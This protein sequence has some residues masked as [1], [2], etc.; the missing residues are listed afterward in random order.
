MKKCFKLFAAFLCLTLVLTTCGSCMEIKKMQDI[1]VETNVPP[2]IVFLGDSIASGCGLEGYSDDDLYNCR[3]Y[4]NILKERY[5]GE[6][7]EKCRQ[8]TINDAVTGDKS[9]DMLKK[10]KNG[11]LD[12][13][14]ADSDAVVVSIGG[15][16]LLGL[17]FEVLTKLGYDPDSD[18]IEL[19]DAN[20]M[21]AVLALLTLD[22]DADAALDGFEANLKEIITAI[23]DKTAGTIIVQT[24]YDPFE[25]FDSIKVLT[26]FTGEK[27]ERLNNIVLKNAMDGDTR[28][29]YVVDVAGDFK[30]KCKDLTNIASFDIHP[31]AKG[32]EEIAEVVD[33]EIRAHV[34]TYPDRIEVVDQE[35]TNLLLII[36]IASC[37]VLVTGIILIVVIVVRK[38]KK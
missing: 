11:E 3:S 33:K 1:T 9:E 17:V 6:L 19:D 15:N 8:I 24:L 20:I 12:E 27:I 14:L 13:A 36:V 29:Y 18:K 28:L 5:S 34:Y 31:N 38:K 4:A 25:F 30:G 32:H 23:R 21:A 35:A 10:L 26:D 7:G 22:K 37:A 16:D 2:K